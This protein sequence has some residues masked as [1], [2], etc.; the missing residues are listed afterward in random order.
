[1]AKRETIHTIELQNLAYKS[2]TLHGFIEYVLDANGMECVAL[3]DLP[4][5][6]TRVVVKD[7]DNRRG[8]VTQ[9]RNGTWV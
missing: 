3:Q 1:M 7:T 8:T 5:G 2:R 4:D 6:G 9:L